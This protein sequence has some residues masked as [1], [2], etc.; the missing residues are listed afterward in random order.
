MVELV[1]SIRV[2][3]INIWP[4]CVKMLASIK[5]FSRKLATRAF[6]ASYELSQQALKE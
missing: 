2:K 1:D 5:S 4:C 6:A 3:Q